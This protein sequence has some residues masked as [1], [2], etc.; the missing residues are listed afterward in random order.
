MR[1]F[2]IVD[3]RNVIDRNTAQQA[4]FLYPV[5][6]LNSPLQIVNPLPIEG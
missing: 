5:V 1:I 6:A 4:R 2:I 3:G